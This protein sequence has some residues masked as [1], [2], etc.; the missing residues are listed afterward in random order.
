MQNIGKDPIG[1]L[2]AGLIIYG[3]WWALNNRNSQLG[4]V[5]IVLILLSVLMVWRIPFFNDLRKAGLL[6]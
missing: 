4:T 3:I 6:K 5:F 2:L 1:Y